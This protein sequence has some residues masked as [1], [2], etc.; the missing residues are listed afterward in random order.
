MTEKEDRAMRHL[1][2]SGHY[3][4][5]ELHRA[6]I[7]ARSISQPAEAAFPPSVVFV[8]AVWLGLATGLLEVSLLFVRQYYV[9]ASAVSALQLNQHAHWMIPISHG[10]IFGTLGFVLAGVAFLTRSR[11]LTATGVYCLSFFA[12]VALLQTCRSLT[13]IACSSLAGGIT[14][15]VT[16]WLV[17][18]AQRPCR[19][20]GISLAGFVGVLGAVYS[21]NAGQETLDL[22]RLP[23]AAPGL[24]NVL[25]I[26]LDTVRAESLS[27]YGYKR[28]TSPRLAEFAQQGVRFDQARTPAAW[29]LPAHA[30]MFT[31]RWPYELST[32]PDRPLDDTYPT[33]AE[34]LRDRGYATAGFAGN[35]YFCSLWYGLGRG[36]LH[37]E[38][39]AL[40]PLEIFRSS[41][42]GRYLLRKFSPGDRSRA[43]A[44]FERKDASA[45]NCEFLDW[46]SSRPDGRPF[47]A[48]LNYY[49]AH[50]PYLPPDGAPRHFGLAPSNSDDLATLRDWLKAIKSELP[51]RTIELARDGYDDCVAYLDDQ[52]GRLFSELGDRGLLENTVVIVTADHGELL[53]ENG[54]F[55]HGQSLRHQV[56]NVP[57]LVVAPRRVPSGKIIPAPVSLRDLPATIVDLVGLTNQS[58]FPGHSLARYWSEPG[59]LT[60]DPEEW[61]L[62]ETADEL[63]KVPVNTRSARSL[64]HHNK[65]YIRK[66]DGREELYDLA[67]DPTES[68]DISRSPES[69]ELMVRFRRMM[70]R[71]DAEAEVLEQIR[72]ATRK[73][74]EPTSRLGDSPAAAGLETPLEERWARST[75]V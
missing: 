34:F 5:E 16:P 18:R 49:D 64:V 63:S 6:E 61:L 11:Q 28:D 2:T 60:A 4:T 47:F 65:L 68:R 38:D 9:D 54:E 12:A 35:T 22:H 13:S 10:M 71:V 62:T 23:A 72:R 20:V 59:A 70:E 21:L 31:G 46:L 8:F 33:L 37:Y 69:Q 24:P 56:A 40:T 19:L 45:I 42:I 1:E 27:L 14:L 41:M 50:D 30:S 67:T 39:V 74:S 26:V 7:R 29:T 51:Q 17:P 36:F 43:T 15:W 73:H 25:M 55:S 66:K 52:I 75:I 48:F 58:P 44:F 3:L 53:G 57:L 32:R